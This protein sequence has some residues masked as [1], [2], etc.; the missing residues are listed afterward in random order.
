MWVVVVAKK[1]QQNC[2]KRLHAFELHNAIGSLTDSKISSNPG[3]G[4]RA[5]LVHCCSVRFPDH[6]EVVTAGCCSTQNLLLGAQSQH[7]L[8]VLSGSP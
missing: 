7:W 3:V 5:R 4:P 8:L 6:L 2:G 1:A